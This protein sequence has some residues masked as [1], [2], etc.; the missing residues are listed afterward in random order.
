ME[1]KKTHEAHLSVAFLKTAQRACQRM[2]KMGFCVVAVF[3]EGRPAAH[4]V[5]RCG[6][7]SQG[8]FA[9]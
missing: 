8:G 9:S 4:W 1:P 5:V 2:R 7:K 3:A 6:H